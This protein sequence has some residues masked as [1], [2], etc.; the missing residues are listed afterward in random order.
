MPRDHEKELFDEYFT[1][2][3]IIMRQVASDPRVGVDDYK[4]IVGFTGSLM[5]KACT[6]A[7]DDAVMDD[8]KD[9]VA[10]LMPE[11]LIEKHAEFMEKHGYGTVRNGYVGRSV[12]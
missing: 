11:S 5:L 8:I 2:F 4:Y 12:H 6:A 9:C 3:D 7:G 1:L 10:V